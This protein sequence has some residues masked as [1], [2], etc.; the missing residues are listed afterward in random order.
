VNFLAR[1]SMTGRAASGSRYANGA[2]SGSA[3][4]NALAAWG[5]INVG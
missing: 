5:E 3:N 2:Y 1:S 4:R